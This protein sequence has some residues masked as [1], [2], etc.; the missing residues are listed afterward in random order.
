V[1]IEW[2]VLPLAAAAC[3]ARFYRRVDVS[4]GTAVLLYRLGQPEVHFTSCWARA[5]LDRWETVSLGP[6]TLKLDRRGKEGLPS[7]DS[8][9]VDVALSF[10][11]EVIRDEE[12]V[13]RLAQSVG[14]QRVGDPRTLEML[15]SHRFAE[16][17][18]ATFARH[19]FDALRQDLETWK[20]ELSVRIGS[21]LKGYRLERID[22]GYLDHTPIAALDPKN[23]TD[24][25]AIR[26]LTERTAVEQI[27]VNEAE[28]A[29]LKA[30]ISARYERSDW[31]ESG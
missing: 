15:F 22:V 10:Q 8:I 12:S 31:T 13:L 25:I 28:K 20:A 3:I 21:D 30:E 4:A 24:A 7:R 2:V 23:S 16:A 9:R 18:A 11:L 26:V 19:D 27:R 29:R 17:A 5:V 6:V 1:G 14:P